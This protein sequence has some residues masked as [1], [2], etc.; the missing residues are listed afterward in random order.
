LPQS[1]FKRP[2]VYAHRGGA[3]LQPEKTIDAY[4]Y[5]LATGADGLEFDVHLSRDGVAV[6]HYDDT[7]ERTTSGRGALRDYTADEL[8]RLDAGYWFQGPSGFTGSSKAGGAG[9]SPGRGDRR[10]PRG[11]TQRTDTQ[12]P[13]YPFRGR[14]VRIPRLQDVLRRYCDA[15]L[16]IELK[17]ANP[18]LAHRT[19][20][21]IRAADAVERVALGSFYWRVLHATRRY[22]P[23]I[24]TGAAQ[25]ETRWALYRS[26]VRW[27]LGHTA[28]REFQVPER[29]GVTTIVTPRFIEHAHRAQLPVKVWT[30][31]TEADMH[32]MLDWGVDALI[33]DRPDL[34]VRTV[35][36]QA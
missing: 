24:P 10:G 27:P 20:D 12:E 28:Y 11:S 36:Q 2:L 23:R 30:V 4:E 5:G 13:V 18:E 7:L 15:R 14:G 3:A 22:E 34:A 8:A 17:T 35:R 16:I 25:E 31:N 9:Q 6:I 32:R 33:T 26:W 21:D 29:S 1:L 19:I